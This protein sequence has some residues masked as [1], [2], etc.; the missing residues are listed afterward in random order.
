[1]MIVITVINAVA[2]VII[3]IIVAI[4]F[5]HAST[6]RPFLL[7]C[8]EQFVKHHLSCTLHKRLG[9]RVY[10]LGMYNWLTCC[11]SL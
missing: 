10:G 4:S 3:L 9:Y 8:F 7:S 2:I 5:T 1:M 11:N 6:A